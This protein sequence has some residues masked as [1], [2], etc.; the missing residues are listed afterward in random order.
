MSDPFDPD[1]EKDAE[2]EDAEGE[3]TESYYGMEAIGIDP[4]EASVP[5]ATTEFENG[6]VDPALRTL[7]W[8]V[9]VAVKLTLLSLTVGAMLVISGEN[10]TLGRRVLV[11]AAVLAGYTIYQYRTSKQ[12]L[13]SGEFDSADEEGSASGESPGDSASGD[14]GVSGGPSGSGRADG[15]AASGSDESPGEPDVEGT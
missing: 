1:P 4:P 15:V 10:P 12:R 11:L 6:D 9:V 3:D 2:G 13:E 8:K 7:F 14:G 5:D